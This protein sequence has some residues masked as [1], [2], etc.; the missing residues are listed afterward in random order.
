M[1]KL[2]FILTIM[3]LGVSCVPSKIVNV[4][5]RH[6]Y[7]NRHRTTTYT[8]PIWIPGRG[9]VLYTEIHPKYRFHQPRYTQPKHRVRRGRN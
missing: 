9:I 1:K 3:M 2:L 4:S 7:Y 6:N 5:S 8:H